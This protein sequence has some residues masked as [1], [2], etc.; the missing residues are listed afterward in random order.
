MESC[1]AGSGVLLYVEL[2]AGKGLC[3]D[4]RDTCVALPAAC[5]DARRASFHSAFPKATLAGFDAALSS[6]NLD[7]AASQLQ[8]FLLGSAFGRRQKPCF[9]DS[10]V[11]ASGLVPMSGSMVK[12]CDVCL[13]FKN[14]GFLRAC[15][16]MSDSQG[17]PSTDV[18]PPRDP[19]TY[20]QLKSPISAWRKSRI[21]SVWLAS[22][23]WEF[24]KIRGPK[25]RPPIYYDPCLRTS[26][27]APSFWKQPFATY[28]LLH[29][30][31]Q[32]S[33]S[34]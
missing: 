11:S 28:V 19:K 16:G 27:K 29:R 10:R 5:K 26:K 13:G 30:Q 33:T 8:A 15:S 17:C 9:P 21:V 1:A 18:P 34:Q 20:L 31:M 14:L 7:S 22:N 3:L 24:P 6:A 23:I 12:L 4:E 2:L 32:S 25:D